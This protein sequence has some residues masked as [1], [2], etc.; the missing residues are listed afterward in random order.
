M[1]TKSS[2]LL[3]FGA[4]VSIASASS[5]PGCLL[6]AVNTFDTPSDVASVCKDKTAKSTIK[7][8]CDAD[9]TEAIKAF[10][11]ICEAAGVE[12]STDMPTSTGKPKASGTG[13]VS[14]TGT[15]TSGDNN[16]GGNGE[17]GEGGLIPSGTGAQAPESTGAAGRLE[18]GVA[19]L[20]A[21]LG[22]MAAL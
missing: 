19:A 21:G 2:L 9:T 20:L 8:F 7:E 4:L 15:S 16:E 12:I 1:F 6:G 3:A 14:P 22:V 13:M 5:P 10:Q 18:V 17:D 11:E